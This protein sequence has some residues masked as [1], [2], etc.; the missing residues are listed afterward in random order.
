MIILL[1]V[2]CP[3]SEHCLDLLRSGKS[4]EALTAFGS[5]TQILLSKIHT[6]YDEKEGW[7]EMKLE[8]LQGHLE[9]NR[10]FIQEANSDALLKSGNKEWKP[11]KGLHRK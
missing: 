8:A 5:R 11:L 10:R 6:C 7:N 1:I 3:I 9:E 4:L 2:S